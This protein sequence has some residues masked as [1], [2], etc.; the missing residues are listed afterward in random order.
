M[1]YFL[2]VVDKLEEADFFLDA[3]KTQCDSFRAFRF[4]FSAYCSAA[5]SVTWVLQ[6]VG[7]QYDGFDTWYSEAS[8]TLQRDPDAKYLVQARNES[9]KE[10]HVPVGSSRPGDAMA[11]QASTLHLFDRL[12]KAAAPAPPP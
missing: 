4:N 11:G 7:S 2:D 3:M 8:A 6:A 12:R 10:G 1:R 9:E 5:R